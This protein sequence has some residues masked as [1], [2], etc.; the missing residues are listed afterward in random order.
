MFSYSYSDA[1]LTFRSPCFASLPTGGTTK[2]RGL[3]PR[4]TL[5]PLGKV[6]VGVV[7]SELSAQFV[8]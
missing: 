4:G 5:R 7:P 8:I 1:R 2:Q 6:C 3:R